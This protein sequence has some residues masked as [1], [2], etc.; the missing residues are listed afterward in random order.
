M[1]IPFVLLYPQWGQAMMVPFGLVV[2]AMIFTSDLRNRDAAV[3]VSEVRGSRMK[4]KVR[5]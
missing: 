5:E 2:M 4:K 1:S 3:S